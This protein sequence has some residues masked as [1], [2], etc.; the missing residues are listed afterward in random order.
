MAKQI[1]TSFLIIFKFPNRRSENLPAR[2][3]SKFNI[4]LF[5]LLV[6]ILGLGFHNQNYLV[7][8]KYFISKFHAPMIQ[9]NLNSKLSNIQKFL[10]C[11]C[12][13]S[14]NYFFSSKFLTPMFI[15]ISIGNVQIFLKFLSSRRILI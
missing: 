10:F 14:P 1:F 12:L 15:N 13:Y 11:S 6:R 3:K 5:Y 7:I 4:I 8:E 9:N 2:S